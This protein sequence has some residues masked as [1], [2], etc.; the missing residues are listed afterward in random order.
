MFG[1]LR[2]CL[3]PYD[4]ISPMRGGPCMRRSRSRGVTVGG[5]EAPILVTVSGISPSDDFTKHEFDAHGVS[6]GTFFH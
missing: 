3:F 2:I 6:L 1:I 5:L 4:P